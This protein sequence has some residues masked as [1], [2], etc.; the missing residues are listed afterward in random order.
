MGTK[1]DLERFTESK[2]NRLIQ[3]DERG[4]VRSF[5]KII[6]SFPAL[7]TQASSNQA[8]DVARIQNSAYRGNVQ[9]DLFGKP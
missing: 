8:A 3:V 6:F 5:V 2:G 4:F 1:S 9:R 7:P